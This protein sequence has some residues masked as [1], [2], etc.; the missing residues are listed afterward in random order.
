MKHS[1]VF[2]KPE[3]LKPDMQNKLIKDVFA[4][5]GRTIIRIVS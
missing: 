3:L 1:P 5:T 4:R 2:D